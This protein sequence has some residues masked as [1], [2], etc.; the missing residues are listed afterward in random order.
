VVPHLSKVDL[1][2]AGA[3]PPPACAGLTRSAPTVYH[4]LHMCRKCQVPGV[5]RAAA[6]LTQGLVQVQDGDERKVG[7]ARHRL[8]HPEPAASEVDQ[9]GEHPE[10]STSGLDAAC[11]FVIDSRS[12]SSWAQTDPSGARHPR[13]M[14]VHSQDSG[15]QPRGAPLDGAVVEDHVQRPAQH[16]EGQADEPGRL[17]LVW[18]QRGRQQPAATLTVAEKC[19]QP[20]HLQEG[21]FVTR[22][23]LE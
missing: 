3:R 5:T 2:Q 22:F 17:H 7:D 15:M 13:C 1:A 16:G 21:E 11:D 10:F 23:S 8:E 4:I 12:G 14:N 19:L 9:P 6:G 20:S 18:Q